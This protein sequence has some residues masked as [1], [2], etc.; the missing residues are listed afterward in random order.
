MIAASPTEPINALA[1]CIPHTERMGRGILFI[2]PA[3]NRIYGTKHRSLLQPNRFRNPVQPPVIGRIY[4]I[5]GRLDP[6]PNKRR[7]HMSTVTVSSIESFVAAV[8][9]AEQR[10]AAGEA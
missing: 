3:P 1:L 10:L 5:T 6:Y 8:E 2:G 7:T 9:A 4:P